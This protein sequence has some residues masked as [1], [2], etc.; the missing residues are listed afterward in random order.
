MR[1]TNKKIWATRRIEQE[2]MSIT[3]PFLLPCCDCSYRVEGI[4]LRSSPNVHLEKIQAE[5]LTQ[6][7]EEAKRPSAQSKCRKRRE[8]GF[9]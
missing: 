5:Y 8:I 7:S 2:G 6:T 9:S 3:A 1:S 4:H